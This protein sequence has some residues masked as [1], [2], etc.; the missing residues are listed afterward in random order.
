[1]IRHLVPSP[2]R[3]ASLRRLRWLAVLCAL[4]AAGCRAHGSFVPVEEF[5]APPQDAEY[6]I[7]PGDL[8]SVRVWN[9]DA[10][11]NPRARVRDDGMIS[12]PFLQDVE[13]A[14]TTPAELSQRLQARLKAYV[15]NPVVTVTVEEIRPLRVSVLGKVTRPGQYEL[16]RG[17]GV[18]AALAAAGGLNDYAD[19]D[20]I[21]VLRAGAA[22]KSPMRI[23]FRYA[24]LTGGDRPAAAFQLRGGDIVVAD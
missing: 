24:A 19:R 5:A 12:V 18:L 4:T 23:R 8:L 10:M 22:G 16:E 7:G 21:F 9:Q 13:V 20:G 17:A 6:H 11:S 2:T 1:M 15:V 3:A 14:G